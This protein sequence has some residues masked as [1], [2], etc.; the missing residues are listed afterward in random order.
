[1][2]DSG[3]LYIPCNVTKHL[4]QLMNEES[5][6]RSYKFALRSENFLSN[7]GGGSAEM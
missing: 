2:C 3:G 7:L 4:Y 5:V 6:C 1:M